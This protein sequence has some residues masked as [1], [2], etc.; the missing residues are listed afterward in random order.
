MTPIGS[1]SRIQSTN[2]DEHHKYVGCQKP[3]HGQAMYGSLLCKVAELLHRL[4]DFEKL[5]IGVKPTRPT[6]NM[7]A[8][9][10]S[11]IAEV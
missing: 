7:A 1:K 11:C 4:S 6:Q 9:V 10:T 2:A 8:I 5:Q 3:D